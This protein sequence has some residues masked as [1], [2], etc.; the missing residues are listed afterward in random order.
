[1]KTEENHAIQNA[2]AQM[3]HITELVE[4][5]RAAR[6]ADNE[7][8]IAAIGQEI[9]EMPLSVEVRGGWHAPGDDDGVEEFRL[10]LSWGGPACQ[11]VGK[12][13]AHGE[14][15]NVEIQYQDWGTPWTRLTEGVDYSALNEFAAC[16]Y[17]GE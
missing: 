6:G 2:V 7:D 4:R 13:S 14:P 8:A 3:A 16:F 15:E 1:M 9:N 11:V 5:L 10:L 17:F 12:L